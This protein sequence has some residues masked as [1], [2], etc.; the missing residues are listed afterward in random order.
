MSLLPGAR[1]GPYEIVS[2]LGEGGMGEVYR[3]QDTRLERA[4]AV[5]VLSTALAADPQ[6][7]ERF[8]REAKTISRLSHPH[9]CTLHDVG[10][11]PAESG[12][13][14]Q[15]LVMEYLE[16]ETLAAR[17][18][19][20]PLK[21]SDALRLGA[22]IARA[23][24][25]AHRVGIVHRDLK[26][27]NVMLTKGGAKL[28]DFG[29]AKPMAR[30]ATGDPTGGPSGVTTEAPLTGP[31]G[32][33]GTVPYMAPE[34]LEGHEADARADIWALGCLLYEMVTGARAFTGQ[35]QASV[36]AAILDREPAPLSSVQPEAP[37][38]LSP[39]VAVCLAKDPDRRWQSAAD[40]ARQL[41]TM[42]GAP[43]NAATAL[44]PRT[45]SSARLA[46]GVALVALVALAT[47]SS[48]RWANRGG[49]V[50]PPVPSMHVML[51]IPPAQPFS[52]LAALAS[53]AT[54]AIAVSPDG[55]R[56]AYVADL[57]G[58]SQVVVRGFTDSEATPVAGTEGADAVFFSPDSQWI[59]FSSGGK[60]KK[61]ALGGGAPMALADVIQIRGA[62]WAD[63]DSIVYS[64]NVY[65]GL[66]RVPAS[67]GSPQA[68]TTL[69]LSR[70]ERNHRWPDVL[71][72]GRAVLFAVGTGGA[73][74]DARIVVQALESGET[75]TI[76]E[77]GTN[78]RYVPTGHIVY[79]RDGALIAIPFDLSQLRVTGPP[80]KVLDDVL[81]ES[82]GAAQF[83]VSASGT[84]LAVPGRG[85]GDGEGTPVW[86]DRQGRVTPTA[87][88]PAQYRGARLSPDGTR[89]VSIG[90]N[91]SDAGVWV[92]DLERG[93]GIRLATPS[94]AISASWFGASDRVIYQSER[95]DGWA[96]VA[97]PA[98]YGQKETEVAELRGLG[99]TASPD[100]RQIAYLTVD[101]RLMI[102]SMADR[103]ERNI[104]VAQ[105]APGPGGRAFSPDGRFL[106]ITSGNDARPQVWV[107]ATQGVERWQVSVDGGSTPRWGPTGRELFYWRG[108]QLVSVPVTTAGSFSAGEPTVLFAGRFDASSF[109][110]SPDGTRFLTLQPP[111]AGPPQFMVVTNWF[112]EVARLVSGPTK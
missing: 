49:A 112:A 41:E 99:A 55:S 52:R 25:A 83:S 87:L 69:D 93:T 107:Y 48:T 9:I 108:Q 43:P 51:P 3:A 31:T 105:V 73:F 24:D 45:A 16:G 58:M 14:M 98:T 80:V 67:G 91:G 59:G 21:T 37:A 79:S 30:A 47:V 18:A 22:E 100:G 40:V 61:V 97:Q 90:G 6:F 68:L 72:G 4:V 104:D 27:G 28:L 44:P 8:A 42:I 23:L 46:W 78:P 60:L 36:V 26:P 82:S 39:L 88:K 66:W 5:K 17:L 109:N 50:L 65:S 11:H 63:D 32:V 29:L 12:P 35:S 86:V 85:L 1:L 13:A 64:P 89:I 102:Y 111:D 103:T 96:I 81:T 71:P 20:G 75:T 56:L 19:R 84:L 95:P 10:D 34:V 101:R 94:R 76:V 70:G 7:R 53:S 62:T 54:L 77:G 2:A 92:H 106:A 38:P 110:V 74:N 57:Q 33:L 15:Y